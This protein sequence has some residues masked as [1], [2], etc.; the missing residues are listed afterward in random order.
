MFLF[1]KAQK[2]FVNISADYEKKRY[3]LSEVKQKQFQALS[4]KLREAI[5]NKRKEETKDLLKALEQFQKKELPPAF[6]SWI[7]GHIGRFLL[8]L[9]VAMLIRQMWFELYMIPTGSMRPTFKEGDYVVVNKTAFSL[10]VPLF[11][12]HFYF[13]QHDL[14]HGNIVVFS[15]DNMDV[16]QADM[17][18]FYLFPGK[19]QLV[20]RLVG[21]PGDTLYFYGG[22]VYGIDKDQKPIAALQNEPCF[23]DIEYIPFLQIGGKVKTPMRTKSG[24][25]PHS[26]IYQMNQPV[27]KLSINPFSNVQGTMLSAAGNRANFHDYHELWGFSHYA[28]AR[29]LTQ[30]AYLNTPNATV[31]K[32]C[33]YYLELTHHPSFQGAQLSPDAMGRVRPDLHYERSYIPLNE[34]SMQRIFT[35]MN[36]VRFVVKDERAY[37]YGRQG[38]HPS[39]PILEGVPDGTY[40]FDRGTL[41]E[42]GRTRTAFSVEETHPL[43]RYTPENTFLLYNLGV[44]FDTHFL[45]ALHEKSWLPSRYAYFREGDL[46]LLGAP[47]LFQNDPLLQAF[48]EQE[49]EKKWSFLDKGPPVLPNGLLDVEKIQK[50]GFSIPEKHYLVLGDNHSI[51]GDSRD[52]GLVPQENFKG[53]ATGIFFPMGHRF[54]F[55]LQPYSSWRTFPKLFTWLIFT[56]SVTVIMLYQRRIRNH[57]WRS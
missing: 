34:E 19:K 26:I 56:C 15:A 39:S 5:C 50:F 32:N 49:S 10:N 21:K 38:P 29:I 1:R 46:Y 42:I 7:T 2:Q 31:T 24:V 6:F 22:K 30:A 36:T 16:A 53:T 11:T 20:K 54:G 37:A 3:R 14:K 52:F 41:Y 25:F 28:A 23:E 4:S 51:S 9:L 18:Y 8:A 40:E 55:T 57:F 48:K 35:H 33:D 45:P 13:S 27:A 44:E 12:S 17:M 43:A 47:I